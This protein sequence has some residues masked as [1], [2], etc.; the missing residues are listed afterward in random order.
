MT[1]I[2][3]IYDQF[4]MVAELS[5]SEDKTVI[6]GHYFQYSFEG[7]CPTF[8]NYKS[9]EYYKEGDFGEYVLAQE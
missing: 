8:E 9:M 7:G 5:I 6:S 4:Y 1:A 3:V 2:Y